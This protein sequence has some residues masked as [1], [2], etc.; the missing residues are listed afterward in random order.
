MNCQEIADLLP[1]YALGACDADERALVEAHLESGCPA[2]ELEVMGFEQAAGT[3]A[4]TAPEADPPAAL[5]D[6]LMARTRGED[7]VEPAPAAQH[8]GA[9]REPIQRGWRAALPYLAAT[10]AAAAC[11]SFA[12]RLTS[13]QAGPDATAQAD[14]AQADSAETVWRARIAE[15]ERRF[16]QPRA[17]RVTFQAGQGAAG[18]APVLMHDEVA[19]EL[20]LYLPA[21]LPVPE[22]DLWAWGRNADGA[23]IGSTRLRPLAGGGAVGVL[24]VEEPFDALVG[25]EITAETDP[26]PSEPSGTVITRGAIAP[27]SA[28][29][30]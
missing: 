19:G 2:C 23:L 9:E 12:A 29:D 8:S 6:A 7:L 11:G 17:T 5:R 25:L 26:E 21:A 24:P 28:G 15:A 30:E 14:S 13:P 20:H 27:R 18:A 4:E 10:L 3:L 1:A 22:G 16:G